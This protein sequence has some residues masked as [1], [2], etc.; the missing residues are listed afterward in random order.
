AKQLEAGAPA[1]LFISADQ[2]WMD[3]AARTALIKPES[4]IN[5]VSNSLVL[6]AA[7]NNGAVLDLRPGVDLKIPLAGQKLAIADPDSVP[8]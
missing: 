7:A 5:L 2:E 8:A 4:R 3:Y 1:D 6:I